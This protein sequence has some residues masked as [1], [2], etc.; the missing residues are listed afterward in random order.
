MNT[1]LPN[2]FGYLCEWNAP[3]GMPDY[4]NAQEFYHR[5]PGSATID[6]WNKFPDVHHNLP[7]YTEEQLKQFATRIGDTSSVISDNDI[8]HAFATTNFGHTNYRELLC[9]SVLKSSVGYHCGNTIT[10]IMRDLK[11]IC[12]TGAPSKRGQLLLRAAYGHLMS[13]SG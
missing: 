7:L 10:V 8:T 13:R 4:G 1:H 2:P 5:E 9:A 6:D 12:V 3:P 11:L